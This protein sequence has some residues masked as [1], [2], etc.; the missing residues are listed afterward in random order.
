MRELGT[1]DKAPCIIIPPGTPVEKL[2]TYTVLDNQ[3][4]EDWDWAMVAGST[5]APRYAFEDLK[6]K[7]RKP[8]DMI[9]GTE[10]GK[11]IKL[12][13][14]TLRTMR[15]KSLIKGRL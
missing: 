5:I 14:F 13:E 11:M 1:F 7:G 12:T 3:Q 4:A 15:C 10:Y 9:L 2:K 6:R 8:R